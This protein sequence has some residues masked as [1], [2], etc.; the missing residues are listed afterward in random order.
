MGGCD[1]LQHIYGL[2]WLFRAFLWVCVGG[3]DW[4]WLGEG[5]FDWVWL[6]VTGYGW[7]GK[8]VKPN[9]GIIMFIAI[10]D[11]IIKLLLSLK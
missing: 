3:C 6:G 9:S 8:M 11:D 2:V 5:R 7:V 10:T 4:M 1:C